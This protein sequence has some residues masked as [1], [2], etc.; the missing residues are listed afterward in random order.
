MAIPPG[1]RTDGNAASTARAPGPFAGIPQMAGRAPGLGG[2]ANYPSNTSNLLGEDN[3]TP[4]MRRV[5]SPDILDQ[6]A[7]LRNANQATTAAAVSNSG[8]VDPGYAAR[9]ANFMATR[10]TPLVNP[11]SGLNLPQMTLQTIAE[12]QRTQIGIERQELEAMRRVAWSPNSGMPGS[13]MGIPPPPGGG[14]SWGT[15]GIP[16]ASN[17]PA[18][19]RGQGNGPGGTG[20]GGTGGG[21]PGGGGGGMGGGRGFGRSGNVF[22]GSLMGTAGGMLGTSPIGRLVELGVAAIMAPQE[23]NAMIQ[24][25][26]SMTA[27]AIDF[28]QRTSAMGRAMGAEGWNGGQ[29]L[30]SI[31]G[32]TGNPVNDLNNYPQWM[33]DAGI[34]PE[35]AVGMVSRFGI[36]PQG[37]NQADEI[38]QGLAG[39]RFTRGFSGMPEGMVEGAA[40]TAAKYGIISADRAGITEFVRQMEPMMTRA[41]ETSLNRAAVMQNMVSYMATMAA[42]GLQP[43]SLGSIGNYISGFAGIAGRT[44][45]APISMDRGLSGFKD[46]ILSDPFATV[47]AT[48]GF[49][50]QFHSM[51]D[52]QKWMNRK[53]PGSYDKLMSDPGSAGVLNAIAQGFKTNGGNM[54]PFMTRSLFEVMDANPTLK[55]AAALDNPLINDPTRDPSI[56]LAIISQQTGAP[57][58]VV[59]AALEGRRTTAASS[60][61]RPTA[62][63]LLNRLQKDLGLSQTGAA[64]VVGNLMQESGLNPGKTNPIGAT[65]LAQWYKERAVAMRA[66]SAAHP[67]LSPMEAQTQ[68]LEQ[69]MRKPKYADLMAQLRDPSVSVKDATVAFRKIFEVP[70]DEEANDAQRI[71]YASD[72]LQGL[73]RAGPRTPGQAVESDEELRKANAMAAVAGISAVSVSL[74]TLSEVF[75][76]VSTTSKLLSI[77]TEGAAQKSQK[78][79]QDNMPK[80]APDLR[81]IQ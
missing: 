30:R 17:I 78:F 51:T 73:Q 50:G 26:H 34:T 42:R 81:G 27:P 39:M 7:K 66:F 33:K 38:A 77:A 71:R 4:L 28:I 52:I 60:A 65:G 9:Q 76:L 54:N 40:G 2:Y 31:F 67:E 61:M 58:S 29:H 75:T 48:V 19:L 74:L 1:V 22:G 44:G 68:F 25:A 49:S 20:G 59:A 12:N 8:Y 63:G 10:A 62:V 69:E 3:L 57:Q 43:A 46:R 15:A 64:G 37:V 18:F 72:T 56:N 47:A 36:A 5:A 53:D 6:L 23:M 13:G 80:G 35:A 45:E 32:I 70:K 41:G 11:S 55:L 16:P 24:G 79:Y 14:G 21:P